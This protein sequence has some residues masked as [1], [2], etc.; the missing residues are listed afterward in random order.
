[1]E[2]VESR[3]RIS[4]SYSGFPTADSMP[5]PNKI[6]KILLL[7]LIVG[8]I[9]VVIIIIIVIITCWRLCLVCEAL[10]E[11]EAAGGVN[12]SKASRVGH[13]FQSRNLA[14]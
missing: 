5:K 14:I 7:L 9:I 4:K 11:L 8:I 13:L 1:M 10:L 3:N 12:R 6:N 2:K